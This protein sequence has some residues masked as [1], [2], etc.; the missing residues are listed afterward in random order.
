MQLFAIIGVV[1]VVLLADKIAQAWWKYADMP[2]Y[3]SSK[4][5]AL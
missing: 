4:Y 1:T 3:D 2:G 5:G